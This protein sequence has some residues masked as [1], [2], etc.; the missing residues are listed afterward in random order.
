[1]VL[2]IFCADFGSINLISVESF[3]QEIT[4]DPWD[5]MVVSLDPWVV[6]VPNSSGQFIMRQGDV[7][8]RI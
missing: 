4:M 1:M 7:M 5:P 6:S 3:N 2:S 8:Y